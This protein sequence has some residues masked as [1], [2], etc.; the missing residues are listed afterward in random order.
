[1]TRIIF[2]FILSA[3]VGQLSAQ[4][5]SQF[6]HFMYNQQYLNPGYVGVRDVPT[7]MG[8]YRNQ[9]L[10][11]EGAPKS[12]QFAFNTPLFKNVGF[13]LSASNHKIGIT[14]TWYT[15]MAYSYNLQLTKSVAVRL[16]LQ[17]SMKYFSINFSDESVFVLDQDDQ[18]IANG[19][20]ANRYSG[21]IG[22]GAYLTVEDNLFVGLSVPH[23]LRTNMGFNRE[24]LE[25]AFDQ[26]HFYLMAGGMFAL[27]KAEK[28]HL[29]PAL[30]AKY[31][32]NAPFDMDINVSVMFNRE[33][34]VG[35]SYRLGGDGMGESLDLLLYYQLSTQL[36]LGV[37]Y[38]FTL[39]ELG[40]YNSGTFEVLLRY[41]V[42]SEQQGLENPRF[43]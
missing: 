10:G 30:L 23:F 29:K 11:Y 40:S 26:P 2:I 28:I 1:M 4:Q 20:A 42:K 6:T 15:N 25:T 43:F 19:M 32:E 37:A 5:E 33:L 16:G 39:S 21:N 36:G 14:N 38:D 41:D 7:F 27:D 24:T 17:G 13:G 9:W 18:S 22:A 31:T 3:V 8:I 34:Q 12:F 35:L